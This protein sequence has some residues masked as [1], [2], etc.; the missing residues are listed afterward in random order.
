[1]VGE[2]RTA[3]STDARKHPIGGTTVEP[4]PAHPAQE[5]RTL[6]GAEVESLVLGS[7]AAAVVGA[8][9][10]GWLG[11]ILLALLA[12]IL[13]RWDQR[14]RHT[15]LIPESLRQAVWLPISAF[16]AGAALLER[17][18][19]ALKQR[20]ATTHEMRQAGGTSQQ[21]AQASTHP[22]GSIPS[23]ALSPGAQS[24]SPAPA[25]DYL[26]RNAIGFGAAVVM[27]VGFFMP[28]MRIFGFGVSG[29]SLGNLGSE[30]NLAWLVLLGAVACIVLYIL[31]R[32]HRLVNA[33]AGALPW[34]LLGY[35]VIDQEI[36]ED[37]FEI[38]AMGAYLVLGAGVALAL[39]PVRTS[40]AAPQGS[41]S[42]TPTFPPVTSQASV[43]LSELRGDAD[44]SA[45]RTYE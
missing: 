19:D 16:D 3:T 6:S 29:S 4:V 26:Q 40:R 39:A 13:L 42:P 44:D 11:A 1:M 12:G 2:V 23:S 36:G 31:K 45:P 9:L 41:V 25:S 17:G 10:F 28:W 21:V 24:A 30:G 34:L 5:R 15:L 32:A 38:M 7:V 27:A 20:Q 18:A 22:L 33:V 8:L 43:P 35:F 37:I 14:R